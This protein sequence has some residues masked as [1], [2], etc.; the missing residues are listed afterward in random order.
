MNIKKFSQHMINFIPSNQNQIY[1]YQKVFTKY[2]NI[3]I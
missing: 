1:W 2:K 3:P